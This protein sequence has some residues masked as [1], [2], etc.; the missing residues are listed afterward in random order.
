MD[1]ERK[2]LEE[3][4]ETKIKEETEELKKENQK[5]KKEVQKLKTGSNTVDGSGPVR[6]EGMS[7][8]QFLKKAGLGTAG[9]AALMSP[10]S[11]LDIRDDSFN[12]YT[13]TG[14]GDLTEYFNV[15]QGGPCEC[16]EC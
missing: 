5:L 16:N 3:I 13:G 7:R 14:T 4:V 9:L 6:S 10:V 11:S 15:E 1:E 8:R 12:V 2:Q